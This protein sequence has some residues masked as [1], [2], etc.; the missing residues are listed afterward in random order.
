MTLFKITLF[1][2]RQK[3]SAAHFT[4]FQNGEVERLH[5]HN[6][7]VSASFSGQN[8]NMGIL[9]PFHDLKPEMNRLCDAWDESVLIPGK[10]PWVHVQEKDGQCEVSVSTPE[11]RR[12]YSFP[13]EEVVV[14]PCDNVTSENLALLLAQNLA[15][16]TRILAPEVLG[17]CVTISETDGQEVTVDFDLTEVTLPQE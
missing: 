5:G 9:F 15:A 11:V 10:A 3:F 8:M 6:Y 14:L 17:L 2:D 4:V 16:R 7:R 13:R 1:K 12:F